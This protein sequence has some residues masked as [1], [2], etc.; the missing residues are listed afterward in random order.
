MHTRKITHI[1]RI[2][3]EIYVW[4]SDKQYRSYG[5]FQWVSRGQQIV[6]T[7][8]KWSDSTFRCNSLILEL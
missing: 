7:F 8:F 3:T 5:E 6:I 1:K 4:K 2:K